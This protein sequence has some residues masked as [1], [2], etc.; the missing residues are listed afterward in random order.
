[1]PLFGRR[2]K[3]DT[4]E[5]MR[6]AAEVGMAHNARV[7][8]GNVAFEPLPRDEPPVAFGPGT[9]LLPASFDPRGPNGRTFP[10]LSEYPISTNLRLQGNKL[11]PFNMLRAVA[12]QVDVV[13]RCI[14]VRKSHLSSLEWD[15]VVRDSTI[16]AMMTEGH[17]LGDAFKT[18]RNQYANE[19]ARA[20]DIMRNPDP[21][22]GYDFTDWLIALLE[23]QLV[24]D[25]VT[26]YPRLS[27]G[28]E[29]LAFELIDGATIKP[30]LDH[31]GGVPAPP[32]PAYQQILH[33]FPRGEYVASVDVDAAYFRDRLVYRPRYRRNWTPYGYSNVEQALAISDLYM[34]RVSWMRAEF[35]DGVAPDVVIETDTDMSPEL[36]RQY[37]EIFNEELAGQT[38]QRKRARLLPKG[39]KLSREEDWAKKYNPEF[40]E[41][42][43]KIICACFDIM[44]SEIG[45][46]PKSGIGGKGHQEGEENTQFRKGTRPTVVW[47][48][49]VINHLLW[50]FTGMPRELEFKFL[51]YED[52]DWKELEEIEDLRVRGARR[53]VNES[54]ANRGEA[55][56]P[57]PEAD[58][59]F[60]TAGD[61][62]HFL[63][64]AAT[65]PEPVPAV[66]EQPSDAMPS[67]EDIA[68]LETY[69]AKRIKSGRPWRDF[70]FAGAGTATAEQLNDAGRAAAASGDLAALKTVIADLG[71]APAPTGAR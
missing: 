34:K 25:A 16:E 69:V 71:K 38:A 7:T 51:G 45:F 61:G 14:E 53:T 21:A 66:D 4:A 67:D 39:F 48:S 35:T 15:V 63:E 5:L 30:L 62:I 41:F 52:Q 43:I 46:T 28:G 64:G 10:R 33:G 70:V 54:R 59:V 65:K 44:P 3:L 12:D 60:V 55:P 9:P 20:V 18:A 22:N 27:L 31:R 42:L 24:I 26:I 1:M 68:K 2:E 19:I 50:T 49:S 11:V 23:D 29:W 58:M 32:E 36:L 37:E 13:R 8:I 40:D 47:V 17:S 6:V 56:L 57:F